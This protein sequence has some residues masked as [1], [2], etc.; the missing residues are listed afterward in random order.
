[1][2]GDTVGMAVGKAI[3]AV[4]GV[5]GAGV[6]APVGSPVGCAVG[7]KVGEGIGAAL[8]L[9]V[10]AVV[11]PAVVTGAPVGSATGW[12]VG[13]IVGP[14]IIL[15]WDTILLTAL[16]ADTADSW[17]DTTIDA[18]ETWKEIP[19]DGWIVGPKVGARVAE[20]P[21]TTN[22]TDPTGTDVDKPGEDNPAGG[23]VGTNE[24]AAV[25]GTPDTIK[26]RGTED[27]PG[28]DKPAGGPVGTNVGAAVSEIPDTMKERG[29]EDAPDNPDK[30]ELVNTILALWADKDMLELMLRIAD[31]FC[32]RE[33]AANEGT[34][35]EPADCN[36]KE[37]ERICT[38]G[39]S[40]GGFVGVSTLT[41]TAA[42]VGALVGRSAPETWVE[43][44]AAVI[45]STSNAFAASSRSIYS[46]LKY[47]LSS[48]LAAST[49]AKQSRNATMVR[50]NARILD[51]Q[52][53][54]ANA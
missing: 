31:T 27:K 53:Q 49:A 38:V 13:A 51:W 47:C 17:L 8:G 4:V 11:G 34:W 22:E 20:I 42:V 26:E 37:R 54:S 44:A 46:K 25:S 7:V 52:Q 3:G 24:G 28:E 39:V 43:T 30:E 2:V 5:I 23:S 9:S 33:C 10:G 36:M 16:T 48:D 35:I 6:G 41:E 32:D 21:D 40:V 29:T 45:E 50:I 19:S 12:T 18:A 1:M 15:T 14:D